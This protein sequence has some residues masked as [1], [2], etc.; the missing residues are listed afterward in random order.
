M[1]LLRTSAQI[2]QLKLQNASGIIL[3]NT[4]G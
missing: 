4:I 2:V 1:K 3:G